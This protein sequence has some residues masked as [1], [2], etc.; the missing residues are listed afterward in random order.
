MSAAV[1]SSPAG[2]GPARPLLPAA[3]ARLA[4]FAALVALGAL[5]WRRM[6]EGLPATRALLWVAVACLAALAVLAAERLPA[7]GRGWAVLGVAAAAWAAAVLASGIP[8][9]LLL[10]PGRWPELAQGVAGGVEI[11]GGVRLPYAGADPWPA[12]VIGAGGALLCTTAALLAFWPVPRGRGYPYLALAVLLAL[13][14]TPV[15]SIGGTRPLA[16]GVA[17]TAL[18][19]G[20]LWLERLPLRPGVGVAALLALAVAGSLPLATAADR[21][22]PW[23]DYRA[24]AEGLGPQAPIGFDFSHGAY[25]PI[26]WP[27]NGSEVLRV[28]SERPRYWKVASLEEFDGRG[29]RDR[30]DAPPPGGEPPQADVLE[31]WRNRPAWTGELTVSIR[32]LRTSAV[33]A[34]GT[35]LGVRRSTRPLRELS[36]P[37]RY[38]A[39]TELR[40]GD[41]YTVEVHEPRPTGTQL[42]GATSGARR[43][44]WDD[45]VTELPFAPERRERPS[46]GIP[47]APEGTVPT[48]AQLRF[49]PFGGPAAPVAGYPGLGVSG[50]GPAALRAS[51]YER[52]WRLARRLRAP[53]RTPFA[54][55]QAVT[56]H[57]QRGF[58]Y[59]ERPPEVP[60]GQAPLEHFLFEGR[61]G[62]CQH[63]SGAMAL[64][65]RMGGVPAR[66]ATGFSPG[67]YSKRKGAWI[68]RD[69]DA[70]SW[71]EAWFDQFGWVTLDPTP[72]ATPARSLIAA[73][74]PAP[75]P[76]V[77]DAAPDDAAGGGGAAG[78]RGGSGLRGDLARDPSG[79]AGPGDA[80]EAADGGGTPVWALLAGGAVALAALIVAALTLA[81]RRRRRL[82]QRGGSP[83]DRAVTELEGAL[84]RSGR[85]APAGTTLRQLEQRLGG[86][87]E[88]AA[89]LRTLRAGRYGPAPPAAPTSAQRRALRRE[90]AAGLGLP[91]RL[92]ALWALPPWPR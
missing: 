42:A 83:L 45:L 16:L 31:D 13:V 9:E 87:P 56:R 4:G 88:A 81:R 19:V 48:S 64:L 20:F 33:P 69:T 80:A 3:W 46:D 77:P 40:R 68:V 79:R 50:S 70:H 26:S 82:P 85:P 6:V 51:A 53:A 12:L 52:T 29:W 73:L 39:E 60:A 24:F 18:T 76:A 62:Y 7:R 75:A 41:S 89:Y 21:D 91:G 23:F 78:G 65:L 44:Q 57:L 2:R 28:R 43:K 22:E 14:A 59:S 61:A 15:V 36:V 71:V 30:G 32:R 90:L 84:R 38:R 8:L 35:V 25:G 54:Y 5:Q 17:L 1:V 63:F 47:V 55:V 67:G 74:E 72:A 86:S 11:L 92:R 37:G 27:R 34:A 49:S 10:R 58:G 66:V